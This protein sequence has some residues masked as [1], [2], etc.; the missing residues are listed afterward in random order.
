MSNLKK[1]ID[2]KVNFEFNREYI[3]VIEDKIQ[4][5]DV[6]FI[7]SP[8]SGSEIDQLRDKYKLGSGPS[9]LITDRAK[10]KMSPDGWYLHSIL[11]DFSYEDAI[12]GLPWELKKPSNNPIIVDSKIID[13]IDTINL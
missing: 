8:G 13:S 2:K 6:D 1:K 3:K 12:E 5:N 7:T 4:K 11:Q 10:F 9:M